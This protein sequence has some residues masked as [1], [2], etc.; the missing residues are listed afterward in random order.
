[1]IRK[2]MLCRTGILFA[3]AVVLA[4]FSTP[5]QEGAKSDLERLYGEFNEISLD[6]SQGFAVK[7][8]LLEHDSFSAKLEDGII[9]FSNKIGGQFYA[10]VFLGKGEMTLRIPEPVKDMQ[11]RNILWGRESEDPSRKGIKGQPFTEAFLVVP[12]DIKAPVNYELLSGKFKIPGSEVAAVT[13]GGLL[14]KHSERAQELFAQQAGPPDWREIPVRTMVWRHLNNFTNEYFEFRANTKDFQWVRFLFNPDFERECRAG[15]IS[16]EAAYGRQQVIE[17]G[18]VSWDRRKDYR[19]AEGGWTANLRERLHE[20]RRTV[21]IFHYDM[22]ITVEKAALLLKNK[23]TM[24]IR[25]RR[26]GARCARFDFLSHWQDDKRKAFL[27]KKCTGAEGNSLPFLHDKD[28]LLVDMG[29]TMEIEKDYSITLEYEAK[30]IKPLDNIVKPDSIDPV[31]WQRILQDFLQFLPAQPSTHTLLNTYPWYPQAGGMENEATYDVKVRV[32]FEFIAAASGH[33]VERWQEEPD[34]ECLHTRLDKPVSF[35]AIIFGRYQMLS[36]KLYGEE[37]SRAE[38]YDDEEEEEGEEDEEINVEEYAKKWGDPTI[39]VY[40]LDRQQRALPAMLDKARNMLHYYNEF[41]QRPFRYEELDIVQMGFFM[42]FGQAPPGL[43][44]LTGEA[45]LRQTELAAHFE[46]IDPGFLEGFLAHELGHEWWPDITGMRN[47]EQDAWLS[48]GFAEYASGLYLENTNG[49]KALCEDA[50][51]QWLKVGGYGGGGILDVKPY[52]QGSIYSPGASYETQV[53]QKGPYVLHMLRSILG[54][55]LFQALLQRFMKDFAGKQ[56]VTPDF[57]DTVRKV[58]FEYVKGDPFKTYRENGTPLS[59]WSPAH[60]DEFLRMGDFYKNLDAWFED[61]YIDP[62]HA[63]IHFSWSAQKDTEKGGYVFTG[64][65]RQDPKEFKMVLAPIIL[66]FKKDSSL[67]RFFVDKPDY[68][69][70]R[71]VDKEPTEVVFDEFKMLAAEVT[72]EAAQ[73]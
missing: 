11:F 64:R 7:N 20:D 59:E 35:F 14:E 42:G 53:Y 27:I 72:V 73:P 6:T 43:V 56:P 52:E 36:G 48:E 70:R 32:P 30:F 1:M 18:G 47:Y 58:I 34:Y 8:F 71:R 69:F 19:Q 31:E 10:A 28:E 21:E 68:E 29:K 44:Q 66:R 46:W 9:F 41:F 37:K 60:R 3:A 26:E 23:M 50:E 61:W 49:F 62:G 38:A 22:G 25:P 39:Y 12:P 67:V 55:E 54:P 2:R 17:K 63:E 65:I 33:T 15:R 24:R 57:I 16:Y 40:A 4:A 13:E 51:A 45:F 5:A